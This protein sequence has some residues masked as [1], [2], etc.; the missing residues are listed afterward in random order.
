[1][2]LAVSE[3]QEQRITREEQDWTAPKL[4]AFGLVFL[5]ICIAVIYAMASFAFSNVTG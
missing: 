3:P 5:G 4:F 2:A 1:L